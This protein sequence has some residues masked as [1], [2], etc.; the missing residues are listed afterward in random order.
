MRIQ[1]ISR[2]SQNLLEGERLLV[3]VMK[4][5]DGKKLEFSIFMM[6]MNKAHVL[7]S[8]DLNLQRRCEVKLGI[9]FS[10]IKPF[11]KVLSFYWV[12]GFF[13]VGQLD[14]EILVSLSLFRFL[15]N[16][17]EQR[18]GLPKQTNRCIR[19]TWNESC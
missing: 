14:H 19:G 13:I 3:T 10:Y 2:P 18:L 7:L 4:Q 15:L 5:W 11:L 6:D 8:F 16:L 17:I 9:N 12:V 1:F